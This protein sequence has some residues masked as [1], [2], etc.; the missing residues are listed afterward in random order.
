M[1]PEDLIHKQNG[2]VICHLKGPGYHNELTD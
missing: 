2:H 1:V